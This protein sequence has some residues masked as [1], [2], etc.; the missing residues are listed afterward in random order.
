MRGD[1]MSSDKIYDIKTI[2]RSLADE[3]QNSNGDGDEEFKETVDGFTD[4]DDNDL[5]ERA[6]D[7]GFLKRRNSGYGQIY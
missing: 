3:D 4:F 6:S 5:N 1:Q 7:S 2:Q